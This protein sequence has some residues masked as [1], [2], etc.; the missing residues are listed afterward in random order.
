VADRR[1]QR[2]LSGIGLVGLVS[3]VVG[4]VGLVG[5]VGLVGRV[6]AVA[7]NADTNSAERRKPETESRSVS[8]GYVSEVGGR[9]SPGR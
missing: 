8:A 2:S 4:R 3:R 1:G 7:R 6:R 9:D 5:L